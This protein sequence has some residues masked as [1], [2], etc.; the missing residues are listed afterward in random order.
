MIKMARFSKTRITLLL[1]FALI[2]SNV[3][4]MLRNH[5]FAER[6]PTSVLASY[7]AAFRIPDLLFNLIVLGVLSS[8]FIPVFMGHL[9]KKDKEGAFRFANNLI[10]Y[11]IIFLGIA[12]LILFF[13]M[14]YLTNFI[15]PG[16]SVEAKN[17]TTHLA[18]I[19][20]FSPI[21]FG[22][23]SIAGGILNSF[24]KFTAYALAPLFYNLGIIFGTIYL[25]PQFGVYG[26]AYGVLIG[27]F[28]H[29]SVQ[30]PGILKLGYRYKPVLDSKDSSLKEIARLAPPRIGGLLANQANFFILTIIGSIIG[31]GSIAYLNLANDIQTF[32]SV[33]FGIS[34]ATA[35]FPV[36]T[37]KASLEKTDDFIREFSI[38]FR[39]ILFFAIPASLGL[40][41]LRGQ[42]TRLILGY[43]FFKII[44]TKLTAAVLGAFALSLFAQSTIPLLVRGF[45]ALKDTKTP[46]YAAFAA[47]LVNIFGSLTLPRLFSQYVID[48][49]K[50]IT[51][52][53]VGLAVAFTIASFIN[54]IIL[55]VALHRR[56]GSLRDTEIAG[57]LT[58]ILI[59]SGIMGAAIQGL[60]YLVSPIINPKHPV[61]GFATQ[62]LIVVFAGAG[63]YFL[64]AYLFRCDEMKGFKKIFQR[65]NGLVRESKELER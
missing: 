54:M 62:T 3:L 64:I 12:S 6:V 13:L 22:L 59:A 8:I 44:D 60:K 34:F 10:N 29:F 15:A 25:T 61:L 51:F 50:N 1:I 26:I 38:S 57:S 23:S 5:F 30:V 28:L 37:E 52:A 53:V 48:P 45:Y 33:V 47:V 36:L 55:F 16:F 63:I 31:G 40:I 56:L 43:G 7:Y 21:L 58:K 11:T 32:V 18:Q 41:L 46:F 65:P 39:Q 24:K 49:E 35:I 2:G 14:P 27:A 9:A 19:M 20:L 4:G 17:L 42:I